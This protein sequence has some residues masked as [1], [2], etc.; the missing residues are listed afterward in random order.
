[1]SSRLVR[2]E[3]AVFRWARVA[4][5]S[6]VAA[7]ACA[8]SR[9]GSLDGPRTDDFGDGSSDA[10]PDPC[11][12]VR[13]SL[14][15]RSIVKRC[16]DEVVSTCPRELACGDGECVEPCVA[17]ERERG[18]RGCEFFFQP[19]PAYAAQQLTGCYAAFVVNSSSVPS[20]LRLDLGGHELDLK[21]SV[22][23]M[24]DGTATFVRHEGPI[25]P[26]DAV[27]VFVADPPYGGNLDHAHVACPEGVTPAT[28]E[29]P[30]TIVRG[31][32]SSF[33]LEA[34]VPVSVSTIFPFGGARSF[35]PS[36]TLLLPVSTWGK[37]HVLVNPWPMGFVLRY[38]RFGPFPAAQIVA[39]ED[40]TVVEIRPTAAIQDDAEF[41]GSSKGV[42][43]SYRL[44]R[45]QYL[46]IAQ[47]EELTG[48][49]V[50]S[51]KPTSIFGAHSCMFIPSDVAACDTA[52][53][54]IPSFAQWGS[55]YAV[56]G[57]APRVGPAE[58]TPYRIVAAVDGTELSYDPAPPAGAPLTLGGGDFA[59]IWTRDPFVVRSQD[60]EHPI[61]VAAYM[62]G[63]N[64]LSA[65]GGPGDPEFV[66]VVPSGQYLSSYSFFSDPTFPNAAIV[67]VRERTERGFEDVELECA[68]GPL[69]GFIP[70]GSGGRFEYV[71]VP[72]ARDF[73][74]QKVGAG[75]CSYGVQRMQSRGTFTA[76]LWGTGPYASYALPGGLA[77]RALV[78]RPLVVR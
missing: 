5:F 69:S 72:L 23:T 66:N 74:P 57:H 31:T 49:I 18:S 42:A 55:E 51:S 45:G 25:A 77:Q 16:T 65:G 73:V 54:Q 15:G 39:K 60:H 29:N 76:T 50:T 38:T 21:D 28:R 20:A 48:S 1:M 8:T 26:G 59:T 47:P 61:Y 19:P 46:Q 27:V 71:H 41:V 63:A 35:I 62:T 64:N 24:A 36:A 14:D 58:T 53:Q 22:Y 4:L 9:A 78:E 13:C 32:S 40:D 33:R 12:L 67:V 30:D 52:Q 6:G 68:G 17:A 37:E 2:S 44:D 43:V 75:T 11:S 70:L 7:S 56:V 10:G 3:L 34:T